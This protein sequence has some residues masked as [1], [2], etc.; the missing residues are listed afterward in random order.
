MLQH[1]TLYPEYM[2]DFQCI[3]DECED[4]CCAGWTVTIDKPTYKQYKRK[5]KQS[6]EQRSFFQGKIDLNSNSKSSL[7]FGLMRM[8]EQGKCKFLNNENLCSIVLEYG[9]DE[10]CQ[11]CKV[12]P[13]SFSVYKKNEHQEMSLSTACPE[14]TRKIIDFNKKMTFSFELNEKFNSYSFI[15]GVQMNE[16]FYAFE[17]RFT[18]IKVLQSDLY[19]LNEKIALIGLLC[20]KINE[21]ENLHFIP[22]ILNSFEELLIDKVN[23]NHLEYGSYFSYELIDF[24]TKTKRTSN[25]MFNDLVQSAITNILH[26]NQL[27]KEKL[28]R[29]DEF[30][31][32]IQ[33]I[34][35]F[36]LEN[37][38]VNYVFK[39][40]FPFKNDSVVNNLFLLNIHFLF[41]K[42]M[43]INEINL[44]FD[45]KEEIYIKLT[46]VIY[47]TGRALE[48]D[49][50]Y[51]DA[52]LNELKKNNHY[53]IAHA[54]NIM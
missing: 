35:P 53:S 6:K 48:H 28:K 2:K 13:R 39:N 52:M 22:E 12:F 5:Q 42:M 4:T 10:L 25:K 17:I 29:F 20:K 26:S 27:Y 21:E 9:P 32:E 49:A 46:N 36:A 44:E 38:L 33:K 24:I 30:E 31:A 51:F 18:V 23:I 15:Q 45:T 40:N 37:Y 43:A 16:K 8:D 14:A 47:S 19:T 1:N 54:L 7:D 41:I 50:Y 3:A 34:F 11:T